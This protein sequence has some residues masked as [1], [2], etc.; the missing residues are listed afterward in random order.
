MKILITLSVLLLLLYLAA[1]VWLYLK[2]RSLLYF[3]SA[4]IETP[5][6]S[7]TILN[8]TT[9]IHITVTNPG[10]T[11]ALLYWGGNGETVAAG[12]GV[13]AEALPD[14][15]TY[16]V[17]YRGYGHSTGKPTK[18]G[19]LSDALMLYDTIS[20]K[21]QKISLFGRSLGTG[22]ASFVASQREADKL[23]LITPYDSIEKVA[24]ER[25]P[26]FPLSLL[27][28]DKYDSLDR[29]PQIKAQTLILIA[30]HDT[31][32]PKKHAYT[33]AQ[34]FPKNQLQV[35]EIKGSHHNDIADTPEYHAIIKRFLKEQ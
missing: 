4:A 29:V 13:F 15:S 23:I 34:A 25:Y 20:S 17:D 26:I 19:I 10:Q 27:I 28:K 1:G 18:A 31:V 3:P 12:A 8:G 2:Q 6:E 35:H 33:L 21:H 5:Y 9:Q 11:H 16:L 22:V 24:K 30:E 7:M 32:V 14:Y